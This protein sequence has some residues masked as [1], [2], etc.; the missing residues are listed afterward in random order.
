MP[1]AI[2]APEHA[3]ERNVTDECGSSFS[4]RYAARAAGAYIERWQRT[5]SQVG[6]AST[7]PDPHWMGVCGLP[8][9][10]PKES[11]ITTMKRSTTFTSRFAVTDEPSVK[12]TVS[13]V[14]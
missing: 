3:L 1:C 7:S 14:G 6:Q 11:P 2:V 12:L 13:L 8:S 5:S 9:P 10:D 4:I